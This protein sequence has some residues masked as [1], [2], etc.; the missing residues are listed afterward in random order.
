M[1][2]R[3]ARASLIAVL[4][5]LASAR[6]APTSLIAQI[7]VGEDHMV[8]I[9]R[10]DVA[11]DL[12]GV[13]Q[14]FPLLL[15]DGGPGPVIAPRSKAVPTGL[16]VETSGPVRAVFDSDHLRVI[17]TDGPG[18]ARI[19]V[20]YTLPVRT[21]LA[22]LVLAPTQTLD[23]VRLVTR[24]TLSYAPQIRPLAPYAYEEQDDDTGTWQILTLL[25]PVRPGTRLRVAVR[26]L[27]APF[28]PYRT[29]ALVGLIAVVAGVGLAALIRGSDG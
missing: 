3:M 27:P 7:L 13:A 18:H 15:P 1:H 8:I 19:E 9:E 22:S 4:A 5:P 28:V 21:A 6:A 16:E 2:R 23:Q 25:E 17:P 10:L 24:R 12:Q 29:V 14:A 26:H 20:R 11:G